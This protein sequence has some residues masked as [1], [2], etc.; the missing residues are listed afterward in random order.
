MVKYIFVTGGVM[1]GI[2]KGVTVASIGKIMQ[3]RGM[4][5]TAVKIDPYINVDAGTMNPYIHGEVFVTE[6]GGETDMDLG[7]YERFLDVNMSREHNIT[8]GQIYLSVIG[9]E[10]RGDFL[11]KCAQIIPHITDEIKERIRSISL[12]DEVDCAIVEVGGTVGDIESL[13]FLEAARQMRL[14][15]GQ[16]NVAYI[17][18]TLVPVIDVVGEQ[19]T[20]PT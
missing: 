11:G 19:K 16:L 13:P 7:T 2:G 15:E 8:T 18:V 1:S 10:R 9:K 20:K 6:D 17:H 3:L 4:K 5:V 12:K 14:E